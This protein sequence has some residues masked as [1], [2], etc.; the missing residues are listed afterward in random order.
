M[1]TP[2]RRRERGLGESRTTRMVSV[3]VARWPFITPVG[4]CWTTAGT[5]GAHVDVD[6]LASNATFTGRISGGHPCDPLVTGCCSGWSTPW[7]RRSRGVHARILA[8]R[9]GVPERGPSP[10]R[11]RGVARVMLGHGVIDWREGLTSFWR[12]SASDTTSCRSAL[13]TT[14]LSRLHEARA[15]HDR[16]L[17]HH[18]AVHGPRRPAVRHGGRLLVVSGLGLRSAVRVP[19]RAGHRTACRRWGSER[20][21]TRRESPPRGGSSATTS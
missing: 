5:R 1:S 11:C 3:V 10:G 21:C 8:P 18:V 16:H 6:P 17:P 2:A 7:P 15:L 20:R 14:S 9:Q 4:G 12:Y 19:D 13:L